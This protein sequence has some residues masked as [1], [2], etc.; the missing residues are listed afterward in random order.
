VLRPDGS[1]L[2][3]S[4]GVARFLGEGCQGQRRRLVALQPVLLQLQPGER[5]RL[6]LGLA[7][8]PQIAVNPGDGSRP[9]GGSGPQHRT[10][11]VA[12][13]LAGAELSMQPMV[14]AN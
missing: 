14:G 7:A 3:V 6:S 13:E 11:T 12:L 10:I 1:V 8:W 2:Q 5:V 4:T 9:L